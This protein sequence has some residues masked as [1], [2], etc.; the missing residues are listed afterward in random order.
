MKTKARPKV[1]KKIVTS[2]ADVGLGHREDFETCPDCNHRMKSEEWDKTALVL[3]LEPRI[4]KSSAVAVVSECPKCFEK[5]WVHA[6]MDGFRWNDAF[7]QDWKDRVKAL[8]E[9]TRLAALR[10]WGASL[11]WNCKHLESGKIDFHAW[12]HCKRGSGPALKECD[13]YEPIEP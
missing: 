1:Q 7:P 8:E 5:S 12:R 3:V 6:R 10:D 13:I 11:C 9:S 2:G 4:W